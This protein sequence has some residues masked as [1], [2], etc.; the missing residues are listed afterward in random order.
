MSDDRGPVVNA[1]DVEEIEYYH[2]DFFGHG[3]RPLTPS[4]PS[5]RLNANLS[6]LPPGRVG[7]PFHTHSLEDE[8]FYVVSGRGMLRYGDAVYELRPGD[9]VACPAGSGVAHQLANPYD[10]DLLY[11]AVGTN[12]PD[13][14]C[15]YPDSGKV[16][17]RR[18]ETIGYLQAADRADGEPEEPLVFSLAKGQTDDSKNDD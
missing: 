6:R 2:G 13:E 17:V 14:V 4:M 16:F 15:T 1:D 7:V 3:Y 5:H 12:D 10:E 9:C 18:L 11:L 8:L